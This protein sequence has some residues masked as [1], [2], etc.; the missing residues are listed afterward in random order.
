MSSISASQAPVFPSPQMRAHDRIA[1]QTASGSISS[2]DQTALDTAVDTIDA[3]LKSSDGAGAA[4]QARLAPEDMKTRIDDLIGQQVQSGS[5]TSE[6]ARTL[7]SV[8]GGESGGSSV[9][10]VGG[11]S[12]GHHHGGPPPVDDDQASA[13][14]QTDATDASAQST[15]DLL[16]TFVKQLQSRQDQTSPYGSGGARTNTA[17]ASA[18]LMNFKV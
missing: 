9:A 3:A 13:G 17:S 12:G 18:L 8:L 6:Q 1:A 10:G 16:T 5:L 2:T 7:K 14:A 15:N 11:R 4:G